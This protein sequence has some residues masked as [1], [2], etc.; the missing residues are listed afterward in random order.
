MSKDSTL[1]SILLGTTCPHCRQVTS[2]PL[3][4]VGRQR[5]P[6]CS[7]CQ[8]E[9]SLEALR[10]LARE[11]GLTALQQLRELNRQGDQSDLPSV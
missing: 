1:D 5:P 6:Q 10:V 2:A 7:L 9:L 11:L 8:G 4:A 3:R